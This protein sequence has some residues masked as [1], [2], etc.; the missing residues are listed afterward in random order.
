M[1]IPP[2]E[3]TERITVHI[4]R[5]FESM[6][7]TFLSNRK[8][9]VQTLRHALNSKDFS[10]IRMLGHRMKG[11]GGGY[12]FDQIS[13]IGDAMERAAIQQDH[14]AAEHHIVQLEDFLA[15]LQVEYR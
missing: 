3:V 6:V 2:R 15:R 14:A 5:D 10:T 4:D 1:H 12:G 9:D 13:E 8:K 11:D 7:P